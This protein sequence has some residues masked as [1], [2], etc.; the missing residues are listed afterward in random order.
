M[1]EKYIILSKSSSIFHK[2]NLEL[3]SC[4]SDFFLKLGEVVFYFQNVGFLSQ[5][6]NI[7]ESLY[8]AVLLS[9]FR[10]S[11]TIIYKYFFTLDFQLIIAT[12]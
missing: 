1:L 5:L 9:Y 4:L 10:V 6:R 11:I 7:I 3:L 8:E 2:H 12:C